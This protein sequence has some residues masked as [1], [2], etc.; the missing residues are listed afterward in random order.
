[1]VGTLPQMPSNDQ[2][3][4]LYAL[5]KQASIG[6]AK[7]SAAPSFFDLVGTAKYEAWTKKNAMSKDTAQEEY[8]KLVETLMGKHS[9]ES[10]RT[11]SAPSRMTSDTPIQKLSEI[12]YPIRKSGEMER[13]EAETIAVNCSDEGIVNVLLNRPTRGNAFNLDSWVEFKK[14]FETINQDESSK[15]VILTGGSKTFSTGMDLSVFASMQELASR[16]SCEGRRR[17]ALGNIIDFLQA[18]ISSTE[19]CKVP[20]IAAISGHCIGG[21]IDLV[22][23]CDLRYCTEDAMFCIKETD[24]GMVAD[25]GTLQRLPKLIG[26]QQ[27]RELAYTGRVFNGSFLYLIF[28]PLFSMLLSTSVF[29][30]N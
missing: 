1:M 3:L 28:L 16:E 2:K 23:A 11:D 5:Y 7:G 29:A 8:I 6:D 9:G 30:S 24:L 13:F 14:C 17:E 25:I 26:D 20:V 21:A 10:T 12:A 22:S 18:S 4:E 27:T 19:N 15:V